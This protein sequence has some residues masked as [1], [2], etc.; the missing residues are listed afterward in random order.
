ME[1]QEGAKTGRKIKNIICIFILAG[2][3]VCYSGCITVIEKKGMFWDSL[4]FAE[5]T[6][7]R[8]RSGK[9]PEVTV[10]EIASEDGK[11]RITITTDIMPNIQFY[12][13]P[14]NQ[15][16]VFYLHTLYFWD[17]HLYGWNEFT[18]DVMGR[19]VLKVWNNYALLRLDPVIEMLDIS[20]GKIRYT[21][22]YLSGSQALA[23]MENRR[24]RIAVLTQWM[25]S[26]SQVPDFKNQKDF[27]RHWFPILF[28]ELVSPKARPPLWKME[29]AV[30]NQA[31][32]I[33]WNETYT[34][35]LLPPNLIALRNSGTL[36]RD[37][38]EAVGWIYLFY[39]W[40]RLAESL[41]EVYLTKKNPK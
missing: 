22:S 40:D 26:R 39:N 10:K 27:E 2:T 9:K 7:T 23:F 36:F 3:A 28:P 5:K 21:H 17:S 15:S 20:E 8:Y 13:S 25:L 11:T 29:T 32:D 1:R 31:G 16:G 41:E 38:E 18:L 24:E 37:W 34:E 30:W 33:R 12:G 14:P 6:L 19:G 35:V 4:G